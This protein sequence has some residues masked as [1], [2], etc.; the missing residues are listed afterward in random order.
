MTRRQFVVAAGGL[1][2]LATADPSSAQVSGRKARVTR[3]AWGALGDGRPVAA[4]VVTNANGVELRIIEYGGI[5]VS[6]RVKDRE[7]RLDDVVHGHDTLAGY[8]PNPPFFGCIVGRY[9]N[10]IGK[11]EFPLDGKKYTLAKNNGENHLH[12]G[13]KGW[14]QAL[15]QGSPFEKAGAAGVILSHVSPDGDEGYPGKVAARV[16]YTLDDKDA[17][18]VLYQATTDKPTVINL[19]QHSYFNLGGAKAA[20]IL[21]HEL[22][23][24]ADRYTPVDDGLIPTGELAP[25]KGTPFDFTTPTRI[26]ARID[27]DNVQIKRGKGYDHNFVVNGEPG[28]LRLAARVVEPTTGRTLE[29]MTTEPGVQFYTANFLD[30]TIKGKGGRSYGRRSAFCL[31]TQHFPDSPNKP[32]FPTTRLNPGQEFKS[33]TVFTFGAQ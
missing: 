33:E 20:D 8:L 11:A 17:L 12:G 6:L 2:S 32:S 25:V 14:N 15:W 30:G 23:L 24:R 19:S 31:E 3:E 9:A 21:G 1:A 28:K 22:V 5:I 7:G 16:T 26:G 13:V 10:R 18:H 27:A 4:F 29:V